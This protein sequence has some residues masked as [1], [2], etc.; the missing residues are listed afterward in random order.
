MPNFFE[1]DKQQ[2]EYYLYI[3][4]N[5]Q[6]NAPLVFALHGYWGD[7]SDMLGLFEEQADEHGFLFVIQLYKIILEQ[8]TGTRTLMK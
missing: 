7:A 4:E 6:P 1:W 3:P 2:R 8:I 5:L